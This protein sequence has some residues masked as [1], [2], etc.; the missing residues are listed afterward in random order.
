MNLLVGTSNT[1]SSSSRV[2]ALAV[3]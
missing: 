2:S 1:E 3:R